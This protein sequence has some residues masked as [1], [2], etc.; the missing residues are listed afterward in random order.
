MKTTI[1]NFRHRLITL[2]TAEIHLPERCRSHE[3]IL[4]DL[5]NEIELIQRKLEKIHKILGE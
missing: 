5:I 2:K 1:D 3:E 4:F